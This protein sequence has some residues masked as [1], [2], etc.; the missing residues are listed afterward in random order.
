MTFIKYYSKVKY[1]Y[2]GGGK[3]ANFDLSE[4]MIVMGQMGWSVVCVLDIPDLHSVGMRTNIN[5]ILVFFERPVK[6][7]VVHVD[8]PG[9]HVSFVPSAPPL[10]TPQVSTEPCPDE[11]PPSYDDLISGPQFSERV[12][13]H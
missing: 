5:T 2:F 12:N 13:I 11:P 1:D 9:P 3:E 7:E 8:K 4:L 10:L 6:P